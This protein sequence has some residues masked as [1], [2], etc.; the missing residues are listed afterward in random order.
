MTDSLLGN[1]VTQRLPFMPQEIA[2]PDVRFGEAFDAAQTQTDTIRAAKGF[3]EESDFQYDPAFEMNVEQ[4]MEAV[5]P[6]YRDWL[7]AQAPRA[8]SADHWDYLRTR[9]MEEVDNLST[10]SQYTGGSI[11]GTMGMYIGA[12]FTDVP[13]LLTNFAAGAGAIKMGATAVRAGYASTMLRA[14]GI[15][16]AANASIESVLAAGNPTTGLAD[17]AIA[18]TGGAVLGGG[19]AGLGR[20][21]RAHKGTIA[22]TMRQRTIEPAKKFLQ[23][24]AEEDFAKVTGG[25]AP[26]V[27]A[28]PV[29]E[30][31]QRYNPVVSTQRKGNNPFEARDAALKSRE[32]IEARLAQ[33][34][35]KELPD[36][37]VAPLGRDMVEGFRE[38]L[39]FIK[40]LPNLKLAAKDVTKANIEFNK[41][42]GELLEQYRDADP[43]GYQQVFGNRD[44]LNPPTKEVEE[45][46][47]QIEKRL[48][49]LSK[50]YEKN[51]AAYSKALDDL[52]TAKDELLAKRDVLDEDLKSIGAAQVR[53]AEE[54]AGPD[55]LGQKFY[56]DETDLF[57]E[58]ADMRMGLSWGDP[59]P[60]SFHEKIAGVRVRIDSA[61]TLERSANDMT[62]GVARKMVADGNTKKGHAV[63]PMTASEEAIKHRDALKGAYQTA[64]Q[65]FY[66]SWLKEQGKKWGRLS[67]LL[68][69]DGSMIRRFNE[70]VYDAIRN[71][72]HES[73]AVMKAAEVAQEVFRRTLEYGQD[74]ALP[75]AKDIPPDPRY[76]PHQI[77][78]TAL[79]DL[80]V[81]YKVSK[82]DLSAGVNDTLAELWY[83]GL[84]SAN[85]TF[86]PEFTAKVANGIAKNLMSRRLGLGLENIADLG[87]M[88]REQLEDMLVDV[89]LDD[90]LRKAF[91]DMMDQTTKHKEA[92]R[93]S[94]LK[95]R[96]NIDMDHAPLMMEYRG[97]DLPS[98][99]KGE[100]VEV[101]LGDLMDKDLEFL[102]ERYV[103]NVVGWSAMHRHFPGKVYNNSSWN[104]M[105][106]DIRRYENDVVKDEKRMRPG[107]GGT[108]NKLEKEIRSLERAKAETVGQSMVDD[109]SSGWSAGRR[110]MTGWNTTT[111]MGQ[112][113]FTQSSEFSKV[114]SDVGMD[115]AMHHMPAVKDYFRILKSG[116]PMTE[117]TAIVHQLMVNYGVGSNYARGGATS[118]VSPDLDGAMY[119]HN[120]KMAY[121]LDKMKGQVTAPMRL[122]MDMGELVWVA[123]MQTKMGQAIKKGG[124][125]EALTKRLRFMGIDE[126]M[127]RRIAKQIKK[128][129]VDRGGNKYM[130]SAEEYVHDFRLN[131]WD[132]YAARDV[133]ELG[134]KRRTSEVIQ[135]NNYGNVP[136]WAV[137][138]FG[139][140][141]W[142]F[143]HFPLAAMTKQLMNTTSYGDARAAY[144][145]SLNSVFAAG[146]YAAQKYT[147]SFF[148]EDS[149]EYRD[150]M[151]T[152]E[153]LAFAAWQ[154]SAWA[155]LTPAVGDVLH[156]MVAGEKIAPYSTRSSGL[157][158]GP[159][160]IPAIAQGQQI[161][162]AVDAIFGEDKS[163]QD[164]YN[165]TRKLLPFQ[166]FI[167]IQ[168]VL[169]IMGQA[170]PDD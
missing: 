63:N 131:D 130:D 71:G 59:K 167:G 31:L 86:D 78:G 22:D 23:R 124:F 150:K 64:R 151:L 68:D 42:K 80:N 27:P 73:E 29:Y 158:Y 146:M 75:G 51:K 136:D 118:R 113:A 14:A 1:P 129:S 154:R 15:D 140:L 81:N 103:D 139:Q 142:Q 160:G 32:D 96:L 153:M 65:A 47:P 7:R 106:D 11:L 92:E 55:L 170:L 156:F 53:D 148:K 54:V 69:Y 163:W 143:R 24:Q 6:M 134:M 121:R 91:F 28:H 61:S 159:M 8:R 13:T 137:T 76:V 16:A 123:G 46:L 135:S 10:I 119:T 88:T 77:S 110:F 56:D 169:N 43:E 112:T 144:T 84:M 94:N 95:S 57:E 141:A 155:G 111:M 157:G 50:Q 67:E 4:E 12:S 108:K 34:E 114:I 19:L 102:L 62:R 117:D 85:Q 20:G 70:Q 166:N 18:A 161:F 97:P 2:E 36:E 45:K 3:V 26:E 33:L 101:R 107:I 5:D 152:P 21:W 116:E 138:D 99:K 147:T 98:R 133:W 168:N 37:P 30:V 83:R 49:K 89:G 100:M 58:I 38:E 9:T 132:D 165:E 126:G 48:E 122:S 90:D 44:R 104:K 128:H 40:D 74:S 66:P 25:T 87:R 82:A 60:G 39:A 52:G 79:G 17:V 35:A 145:M 93:V 162:K 105:M 41:A 149:Q 115:V 125:D 127:E 72:S 109:P 164:A 120:D